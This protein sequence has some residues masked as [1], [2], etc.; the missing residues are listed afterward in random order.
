MRYAIAIVAILMSS[1]PAFANVRPNIIVILADDMGL[2]SVSAFNSRM[3][4]TTPAIDQ[5]AREGMSFTDAHSTSSVCSPTR[6]GLLTGR[7]NWR[8]RLKRG[9]VGKWER[10]LFET[11]RLFNS[12]QAL[13]SSI[14]PRL[15]HATLVGN[16][17]ELEE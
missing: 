11:P 10:P 7:Y 9:I 3:G 13:L 6:Y 16:R 17:H 2:D 12:S 4:M 15:L 8:S 5:L 14:T 1:T